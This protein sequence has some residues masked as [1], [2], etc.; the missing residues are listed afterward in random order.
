LTSNSVMAPKGGKGKAR[1]VPNTA[2]R[3]STRSRKNANTVDATPDVY[4]E[5][6]AEAVAA[7]PVESSDRPLK[8][9]RM[10]RGPV[11]P[12][13]AVQDEQELSSANGK[14]PASSPAK[15]IS[16][17]YES[18]EPTRDR[19]QQTVEYSSESEE[20]DLDFEDVDLGQTANP[21]SAF[22]A[23]DDGIKDI[24]VKIAPPSASKKAVTNRR[25]PATT[26]EKAFRLR[27]HK[28]HFL[29]L[30]GHCMYVNSRCNNS[31]VQ[32]ILGR[33]VDKRMRSYLNPNS[34]DSQFQRNR[35]FLDGLEQAKAAFKAE[36]KITMSGM[37]RPRWSMDG[38]GPGPS[39][40]GEPM[41]LGDFALAA[42]DLEG[43]QD[44]GNQ[45]FC[46]MLRAVGV[47]ARIVCSLQTLP[48]ANPPA[49]S[50][51]PL[52]K[53][54]P[55]V[56]AIASDTDPNLS[57][58]S[59]SDG[60]IGTS[61]AIGK[62]PSVRRRLGQPSF[63]ASPKVAPPP[64]E[65]KKE[66]RT[67][68]YPVYWV[69]AFNTAHQTWVSVDPVVTNTIN[70]P[71]K[72]EPPAS[73]DLNQMIYV[74]AFEEDGVV[75][76]VT[77]RY[78]K[79]FNAKTRRHR[80]ENSE[81]GAKWLK[82]ALRL[83]RR[84][85]RLDRDQVEDAEFAQKEARE[86]LPSNVLDFKGHP[87]Y[88]LERHLRRHEVLHPRREAGK[89]NAGTAARPK[90]EPVFRRQDVLSCKSAVKW[91]QLGR[92]IKQGEQP[93]KH[94]PARASRRRDLEDEDDEGEPSM[95]GLYA[96]HQTHVYVPPAV[97]GGRITK[98]AFG[99]LDVY[100][101]SMV[102]PGGEHI[103]HA[104][105]QQAARALNI[106][107]ADAV[108]GFKFQG[109][110][111]TAV[112][113]GAVVPREYGDAVQAVIAG[114]E[115]QAMEDASRARSLVALRL[116]SRFLRGL[117]IAERV[118]AY[119][120]GSTA[121]DVDGK[122]IEETDFANST[123][124]TVPEAQDPTMPTA[125]QFSIAELTRPSKPARKAKKKGYESDTEHDNNT[126][127]S[128]RPRSHR[129]GIPTI[130]DDEDDE[131]TPHNRDGDDGGGFL[132]EDAQ[133]VVGH[134][135]GFLP[136]AYDE[137]TG[138]GFVPDDL[139][140]GESEGGGFLPEGDGDQG[141]DFL[142][143]DEGTDEMGGGFVPEDVADETG[144]GGFLAE[145]SGVLDT[146]DDP[147]RDA[148]ML[149]TTG[150]DSEPRPDLPGGL[151]DHKPSPDA[152]NRV[153]IPDEINNNATTE[154]VTNIERSRTVDASAL[155]TQAPTEH[156]SIT[157]PGTAA[158]LG[159]T[160]MNE[161]VEGDSDRGS[162]ISHDP[163]DDDAE[164]DWLESD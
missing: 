104:L 53:K 115:H 29:T 20:S 42:R 128:S 13:K 100:V 139:P 149:D 153:P 124:V 50:S 138:G 158:P 80:V 163:E 78:A 154:I 15:P 112:I 93:L 55:T 157:E 125:G 66:V 68:S 37:S 19:P 9:R 77:R 113:E 120:D 5:M 143:E 81:E 137:E 2:P 102:P 133:E 25:K 71:N 162:L 28:I 132:P 43:S 140:A 129:R 27:V 72:I 89:V 148:A 14:T 117:R 141:G 147:P 107:F 82:A 49:K 24:Y 41:D 142:H 18:D 39:S 121:E 31:T 123:A 64:R 16:E 126:V 92:E 6:V 87:Y 21:P 67:L 74:V 108:V 101:P 70:K 144:A 161:D 90:M 60:S 91:Y 47:E 106:D 86:G 155:A 22:M 36:Y 76:D 88:A 103:R 4:G 58:A 73:Y 156:H 69:E 65:K 52:K 79:A 7:E 48:Y 98:N 97:K 84:R 119:G 54:K 35:S 32:T 85:K 57:D 118:A 96:I 33:L 151:D 145:E 11:T 44:T 30:L 152:K 159:D 83:F 111:G 110:Q 62:I 105:A 12:A 51:T 94:I 109:R 122:E 136:E 114:L 61:A 134:S 8:R 23:D 95:T 130:D 34:N 40:G 99:N 1:E 45:L 135:G 164:P 160:I 146:N 56:F 75:R 150:D 131:Y 59:A 38:D 3:R 63:T 17:S 46:A 116:W 127:L 26:V 10:S